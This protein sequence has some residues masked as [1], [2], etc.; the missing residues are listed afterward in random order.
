MGKEIRI[1][2]KDDHKITEDYTF[3]DNNIELERIG[4]DNDSNPSSFVDNKKK[5]EDAFKLRNNPKKETKAR[6]KTRLVGGHN[7][8]SHSPVYE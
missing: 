3:I 1:M 4:N 6:G 7:T 8:K 2:K 5:K